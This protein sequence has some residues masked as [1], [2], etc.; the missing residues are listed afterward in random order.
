MRSD[1]LNFRSFTVATAGV[2]P[3]TQWRE[4]ELALPQDFGHDV[5]PYQRADGT[6]GTVDAP[7]RLAAVTLKFFGYGNNVFSTAA[8]S[9]LLD[10]VCF[11][12]AN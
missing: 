3:S 12:P 4:I 7:G 10:Y 9:V 6:M 5:V 1:Y 11:V 8:K 2:L